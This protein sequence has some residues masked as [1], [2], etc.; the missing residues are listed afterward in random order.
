MAAGFRQSIPECGSTLIELVTVIV[1][2]GILAVNALPN[3]SGGS[4][5]QAR[6]FHGGVVSALRYAQK[7]AVSHRRLVC[8]TLT[9]TN[10]SL[11]IA[12]SS[13]ALGCTATLPGPDGSAIFAQSVAP[14]TIQLTASP[15]GTIYFQSSG[16]VSASANGP[17]AI[18]TVQVTGQPVINV[19]GDTGYVN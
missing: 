1:I 6:S 19:W 8:V 10:V 3:L 11:Q 12:A 4:A 17:A 5:L 2:L 16:L 13:G 9:A 15:S 18:F 7:T 14:G